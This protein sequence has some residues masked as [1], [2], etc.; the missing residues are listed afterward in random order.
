M[1]AG[2]SRA[3]G[4]ASV[5]TSVAR[6]GG[7]LAWEKKG[8][9]LAGMFEGI[10]IKGGFEGSRDQNVLFAL[11]KGHVFCHLGHAVGDSRGHD[12]VC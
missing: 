12:A 3:F 5:V 1:G 10:I 2:A 7:T 11:D 8:Y 6:Q 9:M 4:V